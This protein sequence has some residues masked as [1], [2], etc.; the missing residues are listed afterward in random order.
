MQYCV[1]MCG[2]IGSRFWPFSRCGMPKQFLDFFGTG[3]TL[4]QMTFDR[5][6]PVVP[7]ERILILTNQ[8]Y[9]PIVR[10]QLPQIPE[11]N[12]LL[13][14]AR[15]NTA[16]CIC[17]AANHIIA[18]DPDASIVTLPSDHVVLKE[19]TFHRTLREGFDFVEQG[20]R[21]LTLGITPTN[22]NTGYGYIQIGD[23]VEGWKDIRKVKSFTEKPDLKM[24]EFFLKSGEFFW[25][26]GIFLWKASSILR[27]FEKY[28]PETYQVFEAGKDVW[29]TEDEALFIERNFS[30]APSNS[31]DYAVMEKADN[32]FVRT[33][34]LGWN[35]LGT[36]N[37]LYDISPR[38]QQGNVS[39]GCR[40]IT[41]DCTN[42][43]FAVGSD[44]II[45][46]AG[47]DNFIVAD[48]GN[49]LLIYP[50]S[51]EQEIR[52]IVNEVRENFGDDFV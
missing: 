6:A 22:P 39:Q 3:R 32:V 36:W 12:I 14:P 31:I 35:D 48:N 40:V 11:E 30:T 1:I 47:L 20:D 44:K 18:S 50:L 8:Q 49:A 34:D 2:G 19:E 25:N 16:P 52:S 10:Q 13:E 15:R 21:L 29:G 5:V 27:A 4:L 24:A 9:A 38:N 7:A 28:D 42:S 26:A 41:H 43:M 45:V 46:A 33:V 37:A 23:S 17:W 51:R